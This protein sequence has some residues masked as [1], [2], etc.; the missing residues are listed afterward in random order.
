MKHSIEIKGSGTLRELIDCLEEAKLFIENKI[1]EGQEGDL[2][3]QY[4]LGREVVPS[5]YFFPMEVGVD[6]KII[7]STRLGAKK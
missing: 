5:R 2:D 3:G 1:E 4:A 7:L 6:K